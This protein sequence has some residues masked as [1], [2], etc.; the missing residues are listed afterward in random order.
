MSFLGMSP[1]CPFP[2]VEP[3]KPI[4]VTEVFV[5]CDVS[6]KVCPSAN[7]SVKSANVDDSR[8]APVLY[9]SSKKSTKGIFFY[10]K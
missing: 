8:R 10:K 3:N 7:Y 1:F 2:E 9:N 4:E 5:S 6:M